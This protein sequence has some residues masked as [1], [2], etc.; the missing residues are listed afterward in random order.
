[1]SIPPADTNPHV[2]L[3]RDA[4]GRLKEGTAPPTKGW[5]T[6]TSTLSLL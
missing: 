3:R 4:E 1:M 5:P 2:R 6:G